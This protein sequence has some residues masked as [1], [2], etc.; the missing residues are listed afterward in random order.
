M[1]RN[2]FLGALFTILWACGQPPQR[3]C[4]DFKTGKFSFTTTIDGEEKKTIFSRYEDLE[5]DE[6][7]GKIDSSS[8]RWINDCEYVLKNIHPKNKEEEKSI[9]IKILTTAEASYTFE[10]N[11]IGDTRKFKGTAHKI[12]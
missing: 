5:V 2:L 6:F 7:D 1:I 3:N 11:V 8:I 4:S 9:H 12:D 10:Y